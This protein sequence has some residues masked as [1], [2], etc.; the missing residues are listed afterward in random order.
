MWK[1]KFIF[2]SE[3]SEFEA[4]CNPMHIRQAAVVALSEHEAMFMEIADA[5]TNETLMVVVFR[6]SNPGSGFKFLFPN[7]EI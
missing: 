3:K 5:E 4:Y 7:E 6:E 2:R 1:K